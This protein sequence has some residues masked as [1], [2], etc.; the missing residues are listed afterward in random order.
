MLEE[1]A[2]REPGHGE[3][4]VKI[5]R[6]GVCG[7]ELH[8]PEGPRRE[9]SGGLVMGHEYSGTIEAVGPGVKGLSAGGRVALYPAVGCGRCPACKYGNEILCPQAR[10]L[11]GGYAQ[12]AVIPAASAIPLPE[13]HTPADG[14]LIEPLAVSYYGIKAADISQGERVLV[15]GAGSIALAAIFWARRAGAGRIVAMSRSPR[16]EGLAVE[17]GADAFVTYGDNEISEACGA[18]G[19]PA[20]VVIECVGAPGLLDKAFDHAAIFGRVIALG[21]CSQPDP[22]SAVKAGMKDLTVRFPVGYTRD[23][24]RC[25]A[26]TMLDGHVDPKRMI[27]KVVSLDDLP[28]AF[29]HLLQSHDETKVQI[30]PWD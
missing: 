12:Y 7:S 24:F 29:A 14:A 20:D 10:R 26:Q 18:L 16:R 6:C 22:I 5:E 11:L 2:R 3:V 19:G 23:D 28:E 21:L 13:G 1:R 8:L 15:L 9:F 30:A 17:M 27:S 25:V 4:L